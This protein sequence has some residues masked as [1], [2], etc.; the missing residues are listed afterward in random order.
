MRRMQQF[1]RPVLLGMS[2][3]L[4]QVA[5]GLP[6]GA[7]TPATAAP[8]AQPA[9]TGELPAFQPGLWEYQRTVLN[10]GDAHPQ[11][12]SVRKCSD[13][14]NEIRQRLDELK[15]KGCQFSR[16]TIRGT[17]YQ[18]TWR[19]PSGSGPLVIRDTVTVNSDS[20]Y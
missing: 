13:P 19:C 3:A 5:G 4:A 14:T 20:S 10:M 2:L 16:P 18:S 15:R 9:K 11:K 6:V 1:Y 7:Q 12:S 17:H 8:A